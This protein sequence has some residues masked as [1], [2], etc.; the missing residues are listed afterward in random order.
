M[1]GREARELYKSASNPLGA[2]RGVGEVAKDTINQVGGAVQQSANNLEQGARSNPLGFA[3]KHPGF[4]AR[5]LW[6]QARNNMSRNLSVYDQHL[7]EYGQPGR[8]WVR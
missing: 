7:T 2:L 8:H 3:W 1:T 4:T 5:Y 6:N